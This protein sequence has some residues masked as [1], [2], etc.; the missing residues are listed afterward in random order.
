MAEPPV[1]SVSPGSS[2]PFSADIEAVLFDFDGT[3]AELTIDFGE[4]RRR[5]L[6]LLQER[7]IEPDRLSSRFVLE[8]ITEGAALLRERGGDWR[9]F[10]GAAHAAVRRVELAAA[11][12]GGLF[13]G[14]HATLAWLR[15]T[16]TRFA[17]VTRNCRPAVRLLLD[18]AE[19][20]CPVLLTRDDVSH[21]KPDPR[22]L[23]HAL[24]ALACPAHRSLMVGDHPVDMQTARR[25]GVR[26]AGV[27]TG[28]S[29]REELEQAG[30]EVVWPSV[31]HLLPALRSARG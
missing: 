8:S 28:N 24:E 29:T 20:H 30:A 23:T 5:V 21:L 16:G 4:M 19:L 15:D 18:R 14:A 6:H 1:S 2:L 10:A 12:A 17:I 22:H 27:L 25:A 7:G 9:G 31:E 26:A 11:E 3:L 13:P